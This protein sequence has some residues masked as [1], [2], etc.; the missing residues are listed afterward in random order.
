LLSP[1]FGEVEALGP[2]RRLIDRSRRFDA[3]QS[4]QPALGGHV[5]EQIP[6]ACFDD[7]AKRIDVALDDLSL[8]APVLEVK[9][10]VAEDRVL[11]DAKVR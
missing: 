3:R 5:G 4:K 6:H 11:N 1:R 10:P 2:P 7:Q 9:A 8:G